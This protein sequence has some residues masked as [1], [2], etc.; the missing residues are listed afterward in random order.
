M[1]RVGATMGRFAA[2]ARRP[3]AGCMPAR[4]FAAAGTGRGP[5]SWAGLVV[6]GAV[7]CTFVAY[8]NVE[9]DRLQTLVTTKQKTIGKPSLGGPWSLVDMHGNPVTDADYR[10]KHVLFYYGFTRCPDIWYVV[11]LTGTSHLCAMRFRILLGYCRSLF[12]RGKLSCKRWIAPMN[13]PFLL[14]DRSSFSLAPQPVGVGQGW[15]RAGPARARGGGQI[16]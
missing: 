8:Y 12:W 9:K 6:S 11:Y 7:A 14:P 2:A 10:G 15:G 3:T 13:Q 5:V 1:I 16:R 4:S